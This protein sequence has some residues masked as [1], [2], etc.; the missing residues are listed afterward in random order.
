MP[1][2]NPVSHLP[3]LPS[4]LG[5]FSRPHFFAPQWHQTALGAGGAQPAGKIISV[6]DVTETSGEAVPAQSREPGR[7]VLAEP[8]EWFPSGFVSSGSGVLASPVCPPTPSSSGAL[9]CWLR[10]RASRGYILH[11]T[12]T[13][14]A[15]CEGFC[16]KRK[17]CPRGRC[18]SLDFCSCNQ[19]SV[20]SC[21]LVEGSSQRCFNYRC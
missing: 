3:L 18:S 21:P 20:V 1:L 5:P 15:C 17:V 2:S 9:A 8:R 6:M 16:W 4:P 14:T 10:C 19:K 12:G 11:L 7:L 13:G